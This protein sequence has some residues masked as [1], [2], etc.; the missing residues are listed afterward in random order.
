MCVRTPQLLGA[1][2][3]LAPFR[4]RAPR[5][6]AWRVDLRPICSAPA[7]PDGAPEKNAEQRH[8]GDPDAQ[9]KQRLAGVG[10]N[11]ALKMHRGIPR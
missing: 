5:M 11:Q 6:A 1:P 9:Q 10:F 8:R 4:P 2:L 7:R 3:T